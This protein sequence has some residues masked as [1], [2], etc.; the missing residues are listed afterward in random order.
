MYNVS[1]H[2][3]EKA[4]NC[5]VCLNRDKSVYGTSQMCP[6][7]QLCAPTH[8]CRGCNFKGPGCVLTANTWMDDKYTCVNL[9][10]GDILILGLLQVNSQVDQ[11]IVCVTAHSGHLLHSGAKPEVI[12]VDI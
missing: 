7:M 2:T 4:H 11:F 3:P 12:L 5:D 1:D 6:L 10:D 9:K 8:G